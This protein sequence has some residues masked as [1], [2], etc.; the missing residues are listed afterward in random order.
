[1]P[2]SGEGSCPLTF[3]VANGHSVEIEHLVFETVL[4]DTEGAVNRMTLFDFGR[5]P[6][7]RPQVRQVAVPD[8]S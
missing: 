6:V 4:F 5:L 1:M 7:S 3:T 8:I 2:Q